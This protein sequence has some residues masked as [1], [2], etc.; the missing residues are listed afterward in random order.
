MIEQK[1]YHSLDIETA[2]KINEILKPMGYTIGKLFYEYAMLEIDIRLA[3]KI[4][5]HSNIEQSEENYRK[6][7]EL[8]LKKTS[9][10]Q[11]R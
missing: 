6:L 11:L 10:E 2:K 9:L 1:L 3:S 7:R 8:E 5:Y 4:A